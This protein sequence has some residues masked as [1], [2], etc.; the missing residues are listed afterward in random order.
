MGCPAYDGVG[1]VIAPRLD[2]PG[3]TGDD[4][5]Y[6]VRPGD[7]FDTIGQRFNIS[8]PDLLQANEWERGR[9]LRAGDRLV[10][11]PD[12]VPYGVV[13]ATRNDEINATT[14]ALIDSG[15]LQGTEYVIQPGDTLDH[16]SAQYNVDTQC[17]IERN[18][19]KRVR[20]I[21]PGQI[22]VIPSDC[23]A[24]RG[25][26]FVPANPPNNPSTSNMPP[27]GG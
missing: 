13:P 6:T 21:Y 23:P 1:D 17:V 12:A 4:G 27:S 10:L 26:D 19:L 8:V 5:T 14:Q 3:R 22:V 2:A 18:Q 9:I 20:I 15:E 25:Y 7:T 16:V 24:Y 11:P